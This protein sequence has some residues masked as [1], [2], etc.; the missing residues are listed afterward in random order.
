MMTKRIKSYS[1]LMELDTFEERFRYLQLHGAVG[2]VTFGSER[3]L[4]QRFYQ[5]DNEWLAIR[6][7]IIIRD[8]GCDLGIR[9]RDINDSIIIHHINPILS[10]DIINRTDRLLD[11]DNLICVSSNTHKAIHYSDESLLILDPV[12]RSPNDTCPWRK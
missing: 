12:E 11:P 1:E 5:T 10:Y 3:Y 8:N 7:D 6:D 2:D 9:G 4:N